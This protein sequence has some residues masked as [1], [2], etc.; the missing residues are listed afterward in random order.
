HATGPPPCATSHGTWDTGSAPSSLVG[1]PALSPVVLASVRTSGDRAVPAAC[2][3]FFD[4]AFEAK[5]GLVPLARH[6][7][8]IAASIVEAFGC[9]LPN[10]R[11]PLLGA[12]DQPGVGKYLEVL[13]D[14]LARNLGLG[15]EL[16]DRAGPTCGQAAHQGE[17]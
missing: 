1:A 5:Q 10:A 11:A 6:G 14:G 9:E 12:S 13:G 8:E 3:V 4:E 2:S 7:V 17:P 15:C 16:C